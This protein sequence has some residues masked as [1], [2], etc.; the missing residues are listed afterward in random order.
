MKSKS[1][2]SRVRYLSAECASADCPRCR[3]EVLRGGQPAGGCGCSCHAWHRARRAARLARRADW[4]RQLQPI[5]DQVL[6][7]QLLEDAAAPTLIEAPRRSPGA[8]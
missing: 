2:S 5:G 4:R 1:R 7:E 6:V 8:V 3:G